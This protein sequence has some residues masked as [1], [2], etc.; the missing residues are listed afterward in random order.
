MRPCE[1]S[2]FNASSDQ[3][4]LMRLGSYQCPKFNQ[5]PYVVSGQWSSKLSKYVSF[6]LKTCHQVAENPELECAPLEE[7][8]ELIKVLSVDFVYVEKYFD[9]KE[10]KQSPLKQVLKYEF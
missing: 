9:I 1:R 3:W 8:K 4:D 2:D 6:Q 10:F 7:G 5:H